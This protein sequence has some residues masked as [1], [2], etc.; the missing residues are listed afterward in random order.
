MSTRTRAADQARHNWRRLC[1]SIGDQ[2]KAARLIHGATQAQVAAALGLSQSEISR[3][4]LGLAP[5]ISGLSLSLHAA[6][7]G[8]R[9]SAQLWPVGAAIRDAA[10]ARYIAAFVARVGVRWRVRLEATVPVPGDLR[11]ADILLANDAARVVVEVLTRLTDLQAQLRSAQAKARDLDAPRLVIVV[12]AT[13]ANRRALAATRP[14]LADSF[15]LDSRAVI[16][17]LARGRDPG[18]DAIVLFTA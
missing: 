3:R 12:A 16:A 8:L 18:R 1:R 2:L 9:L 4:E 13:H 6:A 17:A 14:T 11:A 7:V 15:D 5:G 10:Q